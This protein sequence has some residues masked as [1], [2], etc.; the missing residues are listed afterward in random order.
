MT[1][2]DTNFNIKHTKGDTLD[3]TITINLNG[4]AINW[5]SNGYLTATCKVK[6]LPPETSSV[7]DITIDITVNGALRMTSTTV[8]TIPAGTYYYDIQFAKSGSK[9]ETWWNDQPAKFEITQDVT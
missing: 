9:V 7:F 3:K 4:S 2:V 6:S 1:T 8:Q 5:A